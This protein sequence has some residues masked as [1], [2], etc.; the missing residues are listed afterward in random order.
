MQLGIIEGF[1][2]APWTWEARHEALPFLA[3]EGFSLYV[4]APKADRNLRGRWSERHPEGTE[5]ALRA[6]TAEAQR[7]GV[8]TAVGL[9]PLELYTH[10]NADG[11]SRLLRRVE[12]LR[13]L[14]LQGLGLFFDDMRGDLPRLAETQGAI[15]QAVRDEHPGLRLWMCP[16]YYTDHA[17]LDKVF[18][19]RPERYLE[20]LGACL[21]EDVDVFWTGDKVCSTAYAPEALR[22]VQ[23]RLGR[24]LAIWDNYPVNDGPRMCKRLHMNAPGGRP[25]TLSSAVATW[26]CNPMNQPHA[27]RLPLAAIARELLGRPAPTAAE[28]YGPIT[29]N[30]V[31]TFKDAFQH[32]GLDELDDKDAI[33]AAFAA[34]DDAVSR[35]IVHW[36]DGLSVVGPECLT[37]TEEPAS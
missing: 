2:G 37:D 18:G 23:R 36:L 32:V 15:V 35:E 14:G 16:T 13:S 19:Q 9:S 21:P 20:T 10:W 4:Y 7:H 30:L 29:G 25:A 24:P 11:R 1:F 22:A 12:E 26:C 27:S 6:F 3:D 28:I 17:I 5:G 8:D 31:D 33:R 34:A